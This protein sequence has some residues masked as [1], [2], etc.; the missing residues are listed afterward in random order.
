MLSSIFFVRKQSNKDP[1]SF[2]EISSNEQSM[3]LDFTT[4]SKGHNKYNCLTYYKGLRKAK[5]TISIQFFTCAPYL[6]V[7]LKFITV[8]WE[9]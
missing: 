7:K 1:S 5:W 4:H 2:D 8:Q 9:R 3:W 6:Q